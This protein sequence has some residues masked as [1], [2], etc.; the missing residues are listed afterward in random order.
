M[1][2]QPSHEEI[3]DQMYDGVYF[4]DRGMAIRYWNRGAERISGFSRADVLGTRCSDNVLMHVTD[5]G[6]T[7]CGAGCPLARTIEDGEP[8]EGEFHLHHREGHRVPV[9]VRTAPLRGPG[10]AIIGG[11]EVF[12][13]NRSATALRHEIEELTRLALFD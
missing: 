6:T 12:S 2:L 11:V 9:M 3:L 7:V 10:G 5:D 4:V 1:E 13:D 8:R